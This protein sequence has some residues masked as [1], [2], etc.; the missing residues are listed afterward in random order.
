MFEQNKIDV[1]WMDAKF[2]PV[3]EETKDLICVGNDISDMMKIQFTTKED[4]DRY[5][6]RTIPQIIILKRF[7]ACE[8]EIFIKPL[9]PTSLEDTIRL[10]TV[11]M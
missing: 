2:I 3:G 10:V 6:I 9:C 4:I 7:E 1:R 8:F 5:E 11:N